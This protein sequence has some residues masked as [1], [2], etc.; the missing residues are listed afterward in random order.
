[1]KVGN[2]VPRTGINIDG[3][4]GKSKLDFSD[5]FNQTNKSKTKEELDGYMKEIKNIGEKLINT[6]N[7]TDVIK[8]KQVVKSYLKSVVDYVYSL[9]KNT[10]FWDGNYFT[11]VKTVNEKLEEMTRELIYEQK[12]NIDMASKIDEIN[13]LL[14]DIYI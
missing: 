5:S 8:Y 6:Q 4:S 1:M 10:S 14:L 11:T 9:N 2:I 13:G 12:E 3:K 7:Y